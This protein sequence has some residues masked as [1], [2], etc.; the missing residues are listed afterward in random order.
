VL[1]KSEMVKEGILRKILPIR[2]KWVDSCIYSIIE[3]D[4]KN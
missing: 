2:G 1:E 3:D 4:Y